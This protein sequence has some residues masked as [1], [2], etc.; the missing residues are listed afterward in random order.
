M[1]LLA[2]YHNIFALEDG[3]MGC[4]EDTEHKTEVTDLRPFKKRPQN[5]P[6]DALDEVKEHL[7]HMF[8]VGAIKPGKSAWCNAVVI[9]QKKDRDICQN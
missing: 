8:D 4:T 6:S 9:V 3:E 1:N 5:I 7:D 2:E